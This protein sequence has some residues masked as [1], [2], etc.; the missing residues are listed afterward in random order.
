[1]LT[2]YRK[3]LFCASPA[4]RVT[5]GRPDPPTRDGPGLATSTKSWVGA[6]DHS[7]NSMNSCRGI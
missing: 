7:R 2:N 1:M 4:R 6:D 5:G 3:Y